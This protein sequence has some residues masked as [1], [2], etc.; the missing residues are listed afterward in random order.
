MPKNLF[1]ITA[2]RVRKVHFRLTWDAQKRCRLNSLRGLL[3]ERPGNFTRVKSKTCWIVA[4]FLAHKSISFASLTDSFIV[5]FS[6]LLKFWSR[7]QQG[8]HKIAL[9]ARKVTRLWR[10][11]QAFK[12]LYFVGIDGPCK[13]WLWNRLTCLF[14]LFN[15]EN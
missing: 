13:P 5:S 12:G 7:M 15:L 10:N 11:W 14:S 8:K 2:G 4:Q 9:R 1:K 3:L 6:K